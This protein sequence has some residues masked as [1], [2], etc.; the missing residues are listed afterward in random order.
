[1]QPKIANQESI[2]Q[3]ILNDLISNGKHLTINNITEIL[4]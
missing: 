1:M 2:D 4:K 3:Q